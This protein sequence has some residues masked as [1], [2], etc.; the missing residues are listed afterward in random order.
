MLTLRVVLD[1]NVLLSGIAYPQSIPGRLLLAWRQGAFELLLSEYIIE[2]FRRVM[3]RLVHRHGLSSAEV[4]DLIESW[5]LQVDLLEPATSD[6][7]MVRD[8]ADVAV[9]GTFI[10]ARALG[11][12]CY[13]VTGDKDLLAL[14][15]AYSIV[16]PAEFWARHGKVAE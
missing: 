16:T 4:D 5:M 2:E 12:P 6:D 14:A 15:G 10:A 1:T 8:A 9:L 11:N 7:V 3:P 13:L